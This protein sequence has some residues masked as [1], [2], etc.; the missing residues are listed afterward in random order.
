MACLDADG[1]GKRPT[2]A[3]APAPSPAPAAEWPSRSYWPSDPP[4]L[5]VTDPCSVPS[6][7]STHRGVASH[8]LESPL[9]AHSSSPTH[10]GARQ[11]P[12]P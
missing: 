1:Y 11:T 12:P 9:I 8:A 7:L 2:P 10:A 3:P 5:R 6:P 4:L